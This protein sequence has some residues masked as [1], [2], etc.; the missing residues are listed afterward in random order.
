MSEWKPASKLDTLR[1]L[2]DEITS[3]PLAHR[4]YCLTLH[5][6]NTRCNCKLEEMQKK[7]RKYQERRGT[8][9]QRHQERLAKKV[10]K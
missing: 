4:S 3:Y 10:K 2:L 6:K 5:M 9:I 7:I 8:E 1:A